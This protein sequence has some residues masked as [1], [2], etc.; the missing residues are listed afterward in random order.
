MTKKKAVEEE[1]IYEPDDEGL[2][3]GEDF[4][5]DEEDEV[6]IPDPVHSLPSNFVKEA[7]KQGIPVDYLTQM[8]L[9]DQ[10]LVGKSDVFR[11]KVINIMLRSRIKANDPIFLLLL[12]IGELE[13]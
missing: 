8:S 2:F 7:R 12:A 9:L 11:S 1:E 5:P 10:C 3:Q 6:E 4:D 13:L